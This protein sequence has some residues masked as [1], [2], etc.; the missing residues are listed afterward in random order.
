MEISIQAYK[1]SSSFKEAQPWLKGMP[2]GKLKTNKQTYL[3]GF[4]QLRL[5]FETCLFEGGRPKG[6][7][8]P[9][10]AHL[11]SC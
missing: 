8:T 9:Q 4:P 3:Q 5:T 7:W 11:F 6:L 2:A 10:L 1:H